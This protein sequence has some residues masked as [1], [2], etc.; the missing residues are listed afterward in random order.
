MDLEG[1]VSKGVMAPYWS[2]LS[3]DYI[4]MKKPDSP[5]MQR[6]RDGRW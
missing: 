5:A 6:A 1:I 3:R 4:K 2:G